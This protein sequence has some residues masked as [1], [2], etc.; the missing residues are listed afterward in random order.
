MITK[1]FAVKR[2][3][4]TVLSLGM[5]LS[6]A[7]CKRVDLSEVLKTDP[8]GYTPKQIKEEIM[9]QVAETV[10]EA[11]EKD[12]EDKL[13]SVF[14][15]SA[16]AETT[17]WDLGCE[18]IFDLYEGTHTDIRDYNYSQYETYKMDESINLH[19]LCRCGRQG[20]PTGLGRCSRK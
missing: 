6:L 1:S 12:D 16:L 19:L 11:L 17:D 13:K 3:I 5:L 20:V 2:I 8:M 10:V 18:Y 7:S 4:L 9:P 14:S 15:K